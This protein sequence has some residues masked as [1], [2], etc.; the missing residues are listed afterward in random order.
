MR[1]VVRFA[2]LRAVRCNCTIC[3]KKGFLH[4]IVAGDDLHVSQGRAALREYQFGTHT[5]RHLFCGTCGIHPFY[6]P[7]SHP[8]GYSV[9]VHA[10]D[11][12]EVRAQF[13]IEDFDGQNWEQSVTS[14]R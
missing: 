5:A 8:D 13:V 3:T 12:A 6:V 14:L 2:E 1:F 10:L 11:S 7:R 9:N 4:L